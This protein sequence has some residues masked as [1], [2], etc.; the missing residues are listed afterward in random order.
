MSSLRF[1]VFFFMFA[2]CSFFSLATAQYSVNLPYKQIAV[3]KNANKAIFD[4]DAFI[5]EPGRP[6]L[7]FYDISILI[8]PEINF[9]DVTVRLND[10]EY[11]DLSETFEID[12]A[13]I[14]DSSRISECI[15]DKKDTSVYRSN[16]F[17]PS[18]FKGNVVF[19]K[20]WHYKVVRVTVYPYLYNPVQNKLRKLT[21]GSIS[22]SFEE[23]QANFNNK[24]RILGAENTL[25]DVV[26]NP[27]VL[28]LY[29][30]MP[31]SYSFFAQGSEDA[32][33]NAPALGKQYAIITTNAIYT[34]CKSQIDIYKAHLE[35]SGYDKVEIV[36]ENEWHSA[37]TAEERFNNIRAW[38]IDYAAKGNTD[39]NVLLIGNPDPENGDVP[40]YVLTNISSSYGTDYFYGDLDAGLT[41]VN[42]NL[43]EVAVG[44]IP[45]YSVSDYSRVSNYLQKVI[46]YKTSSTIEW[47]SF[48]LL[49]LVPCFEPTSTPNDFEIGNSIKQIWDAAG[50]ESRRLFEPYGWNKDYKGFYPD[51]VNAMP[52][53]EVPFCNPDIVVDNWNNYTPGLVLWHTHGNTKKAVSVLSVDDIPRLKTN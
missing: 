12:P 14:I 46:D 7:P 27:E 33:V 37:A 6:N 26:V 51:A 15:V 34:G 25:R 38:I 29:G 40:M 42:A 4:T 44:R 21:G 18:D 23:K 5:C 28:G 35:S 53:V 49:P 2:C 36:T 8:P 20:L 9:E 48:A 3:E 1:I 32:S 31:A 17:F 45:V 50:W 47:R 52:L 43:Q 30:T 11:Q 10:L 22:L 39:L 41:D 13:E 19:D 16:K 24:L